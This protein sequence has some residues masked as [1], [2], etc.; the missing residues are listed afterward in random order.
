MPHFER[1]IPEDDNRERM[2]CAEC[3][4]IDYQNP[5]VVVGSVVKRLIVMGMVNSK[6]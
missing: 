5:K 3:G 1:R 4:F 6:P 2:I